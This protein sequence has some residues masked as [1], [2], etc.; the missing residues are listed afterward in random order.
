[1]VKVIRYKVTYN[2]D[3]PVNLV[4]AQPGV[5]FNEDKAIEC[6]NLICDEL[7]KKANEPFEVELTEIDEWDSEIKLLRSYSYN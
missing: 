4:D 7:E 2:I 1:M 5:F 3:E 6:F